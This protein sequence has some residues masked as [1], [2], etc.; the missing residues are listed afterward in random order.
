ML[1]AACAPQFFPGGKRSGTPQIDTNTLVTAD[2]AHLPWRIWPAEKQP[3][4][5]V[6]IALHGFND[7]S[8]AFEKPAAWWAK[9]GL[10]V[11]AYD[12]RGFGAG[13]H[14]GYWSDAETM[15]LDLRD[16][17]I[18]VRKNHP[19]TSVYLLG[20]SMGAAVILAALGDD[21]IPS[22]DTISGVILVGPAVRGPSTLNPFLRFALWFGAHTVPANNLTGEGLKIKP[23]DNIPM[24]RALGRDPLVI[25]STRVDTLYGLVLLMGNALEASQRLHHPALVLGAGDDQL[26]PGHAHEILLELLQGE[27]TEAVYPNGYHMLLRDLQARVVWQDILAWIENHDAPLPSGLGRKIKSSRETVR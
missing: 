6:I 9:S 23:S 26:V 15:A 5:A 13:P 24:L 1:T 14:P 2:Q 21:H 27:R 8:R 7:Y 18:A 22:G 3:A 12:Q 11:Y 20:S 4:K 16:A 25:K 17:V 19:Q 10:A